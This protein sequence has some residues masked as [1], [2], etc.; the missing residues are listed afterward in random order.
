M[1]SWDD[2]N[3]EPQEIKPQVAVAASNKWE[4]EDEDDDVKDCWEDE[5]EEKSSG[6]KSE[7]K[8]K[9]YAKP[10]RKPLA[11]RIAEKERLK[12]EEM[13]RRMRLEED[14][15]TPEEKFKRQQ[16]S[17]I[18]CALETT[19]GSAAVEGAGAID[20]GAPNT[21][22]EFDEFANALMTKIQPLSKSMEY[23]TFSEN[24]IR[25][26]CATLTS[27]DLK[28]IKTTIDNLYLEKQKI[29]KGDKAKKNKGKGK[30]KLKVEGSNQYSAY[31]GDYDDFD[32][33]M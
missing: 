31:V 25:N 10:K 20:G 33:F 15:M 14:E 12:R 2:E 11:E 28:K 23:P 21:K 26:I 22:E 30:V 32:E 29:E 24:L 17:D 3:F 27:F 7:D 16:E 13:E 18:A 8:E 1:E 9:L 19:F 6:D 5:E 4:G